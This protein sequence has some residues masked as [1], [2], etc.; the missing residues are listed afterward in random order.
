MARRYDLFS[1]LLASPVL[2]KRKETR[3]M[4]RKEKKRQEENQEGRGDKNEMQKN[5]K[6]KK[7]RYPEAGGAGSESKA[8]VEL[9]EG[10][11]RW[12]QS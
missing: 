11:E 2:K 12:H 1:A 4:K 7:K 8:A 3:K 10:N 6:I 5:E 9:C